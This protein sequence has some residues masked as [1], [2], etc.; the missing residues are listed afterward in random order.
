MPTKRS[1]L[2]AILLGG[3]VAGTIDIGAAALIS[4][5]PLPAI[6][7]FIAGGLIGPAG[8]RAG[9]MEIAALGMILQWAMS[10]IIAAIYVLASLRLTVLRRKWALCG[11]AYGVPVYFVMNYVVMPLSLIHRTPKFVPLS[12][13]ENLAAMLLFGLIIAFFAGRMDRT[14][15]R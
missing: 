13:A 5:A 2:T 15:D 10:L 1:I 7:K 6:L 4:G 14:A 11:L 3:F 9:G 8:A 12:F